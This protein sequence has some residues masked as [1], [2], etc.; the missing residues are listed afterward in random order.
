MKTIILTLL[1]L[2]VAAPVKA[3]PL[4][5]YSW[6][7][8]GVE[9]VVP[10]VWAR[11]RWE[12][13]APAGKDYHNER[14][15]LAEARGVARKLLDRPPGQR[16]LYIHGLGQTSDGLF[17][18]NPAVTWTR[19][20]NVGPTRRWVEH[21]LSGLKAAGVESLDYV[22][23]DMEAGPGYWGLADPSATL[24]AIQASDAPRARAL[25]AAL[26]QADA[27]K[28]ADAGQSRELVKAFDDAAGK[29]VG[30]A[31]T[32]AVFEP[33]QAA[34]PGTPT[35][36]YG[37][38]ATA[39]ATVDHNGWARPATPD[40]PYGTHSSPPLYC[41]VAGRH[42]N[43]P[44][45]AGD[46]AA[47]ALMAWHD[48]RETLAAHLKSGV[49][50]APWYAEPD[51]GAA[52][53]ERWA[54]ALRADVAA[55]VRVILLWGDAGDGPQRWSADDAALLRRLLPELRALAEAGP[56]DA[57]LMRQAAIEARRPRADGVS[58]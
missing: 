43:D 21:L 7:D 30:E 57:A 27:A 15:P 40:L 54:E 39:R 36:N 22:V 38:G 55:G 45:V 32:R 5:V 44:A 53:R 26:R 50:V 33:L 8:Y 19:G 51:Y 17:A 18:Q 2:A 52:G 4:R 58:E 47:Q 41:T 49:P 42:Q 24:R 46:P 3:E 13:F 28:F 56:V 14:D 31:L 20:P 29:I 23:L 35:S 12:H 11:H 37:P 9:G 1:L 6:D 48:D 10:M 16:V 34:Y 25:P